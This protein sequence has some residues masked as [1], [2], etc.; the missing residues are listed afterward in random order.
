MYPTDSDYSYWQLIVLTSIL[1]SNISKTLKFND[2]LPSD[3]R[4]WYIQQRF[5][6]K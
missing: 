1:L 6:T 3:F 4:G 5:Y 2:L